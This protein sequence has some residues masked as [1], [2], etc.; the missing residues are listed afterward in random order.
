MATDSIFL[1]NA[2]MAALGAAGA[3]SAAQFRSNLNGLAQDADD[4]IIYDTDGGFLWYDADGNG[5]GA[6]LRLANLS[7]ALALTAA[8][9]TII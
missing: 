9:F 6:A 7:A 2:V 4:R 8:D 1:D 3:L 5:A